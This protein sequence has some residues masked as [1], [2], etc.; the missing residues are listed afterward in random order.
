MKGL[1]YLHSAILFGV[2]KQLQAESGK[3]DLKKKLEDLEKQKEELQA[4]VK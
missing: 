3:E 1:H 2:R 4:R